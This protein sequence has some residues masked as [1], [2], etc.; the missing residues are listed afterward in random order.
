MDSAGFYQ[1]GSSLTHSLGESSLVIP[2]NG[3]PRPYGHGQRQHLFSQPDF[4]AVNQK[5]D[6]V[7]AVIMEQKE[8]GIFFGW[9][10]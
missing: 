8:A 4:V 3:Y 2:L 10:V 7:L 5:L 1:Q 9:P 6:H